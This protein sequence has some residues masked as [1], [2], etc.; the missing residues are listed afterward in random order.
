MFLLVRTG[1]PKDYLIVQEPGDTPSKKCRILGFWISKLD[2]LLSP[3]FLHV[4]P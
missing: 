3:T 1:L 4:S 2:N